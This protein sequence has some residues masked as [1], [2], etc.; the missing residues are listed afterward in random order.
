MGA[1][2]A[3]SVGMAPI[4]PKSRKTKCSLLDLTLEHQ[5]CQ[6]LRRNYPCQW[7]VPRSSALSKSIIAFGNLV[8]DIAG[9]AS[10]NRKMAQ[11]CEIRREMP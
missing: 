1:M 5:H 4:F 8:I 9:R 11:T 10:H 3:A 2:P 7:R 6:A